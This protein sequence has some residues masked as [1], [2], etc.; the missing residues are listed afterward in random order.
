MDPD[1]RLDDEL[2]E[3]RKKRLREMEQALSRRETPT[4]LQVTEETIGGVIRSHPRVLID[5]WAEWC[6][7]CRTV[8][9]AIEELA[10]EFEGRVTVGKCNVDENPRIAAQ[11]SISAIPTLILFSHGQLVDRITGAYP[12]AQI[13]QRM[14]RAFGE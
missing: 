5:F 3:L 2:Q 4:V 11:L 10:M 12:K 6:G 7:P 14:Q 1:D 9:P 8:G 13:R